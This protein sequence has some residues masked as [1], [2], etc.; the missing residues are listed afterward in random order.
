VSC[1]N[2]VR[3]SIIIDNHLFVIVKLLNIFFIKLNGLCFLH[4]MFFDFLIID[5][6]MLINRI[7]VLLERFSV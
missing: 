7:L 5:L 6:K 3:G 1:Y 4:K 2:I